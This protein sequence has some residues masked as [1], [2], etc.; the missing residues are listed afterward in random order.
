MIRFAFA[1]VLLLLV[2]VE[3]LYVDVR[4]VWETVKL[5]QINVTLCRFTVR[6]A[7]TMLKKN[8]RTA[9]PLNAR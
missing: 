3:Y 2:D 8:S 4:K 6:L 1:C 7:K 9:E 5:K